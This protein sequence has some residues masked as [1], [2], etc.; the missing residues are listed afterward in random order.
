MTIS[1]EEL[2][3][4]PAVREFGEDNN[5]DLSWLDTRGEWGVK[6]EPSKRGLTLGD[7]QLGSYGEPGDHSDNMTGRPGPE[8]GM[9]LTGSVDTRFDPKRIYGYQML[10]YFMK[11]PFKDSGVLLLM[12][13]GTQSNPCQMILKEPS[14]S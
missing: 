14:A 2:D 4:A 13:H 10:M 5:L 11:N 9:T 12:F 6:A 7:I 8:P 1:K 3:L